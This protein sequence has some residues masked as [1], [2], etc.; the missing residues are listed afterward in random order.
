MTKRK[1]INTI[2]PNKET[3]SKRKNNTEGNINYNKVNNT[4]SI[5]AQNLYNK[6]SHKDNPNPK[7]NKE[8]NPNRE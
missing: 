2:T 7:S 5:Q 6:N 3:Q 4:N 1:I 8:T